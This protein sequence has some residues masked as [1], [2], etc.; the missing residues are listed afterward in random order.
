MLLVTQN[1][2]HANH[3]IHFYIN[4]AVSDQN[5]KWHQVH[6]LITPGFSD[7]LSGICAGWC[8][9]SMIDSRLNGTWL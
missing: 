6:M 2:L 1:S 4:T 8:S 5:A 7:R 9:K 3:K